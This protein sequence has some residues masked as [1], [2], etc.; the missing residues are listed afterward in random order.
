MTNY[1]LP[2][3]TDLT[4]LHFAILSRSYGQVQKRLEHYSRQIDSHYRLLTPLECALG[5][6]EGLRLLASAGYH[7]AEAVRLAIFR[8]DVDSIQHILSAESILFE[9]RP[10]KSV[11][12][13]RRWDEWTPRNVMEAVLCS[14]CRPCQRLISPW[15]PCGTQIC[16]L[17]TH[18][19]LKTETRTRLR[20]RNLLVDAIKNRRASLAELARKVFPLQKLQEL[21]INLEGP[22]DS[23]ALKAYQA[24]QD[25]G[26]YV[27]PA[28]Y[29][30]DRTLLFSFNPACK[31]G[32]FHLMISL[33]ENGLCDPTC[34]YEDSTPLTRI[35]QAPATGGL[36]EEAIRLLFDL[37][38][39][40]TFPASS[41]M[42]NFLFYLAYVY[43][44]P[45]RYQ[46]NH[47]RF[48]SFRRLGL[49]SASDS[50]MSVDATAPAARCTS[51]SIISMVARQCN[52]TQR[53]SC[54]CW[55]SSG[56]CLPLHKFQSQI[57]L[58]DSNAPPPYAPTIVFS[59][60]KTWYE[61]SEAL[62]AWIQDCH[63]DYNQTRQYLRDACRLE[64]F[65]R[66]GM[67]HTCCQFTFVYHNRT[68]NT[69]GLPV[70]MSQKDRNTRQELQEED[71]ELSDQLEIIMTAYDQAW[72]LYTG[73]SK[74]FWEWWWAKLQVL[75]PEIPTS[76]RDR[77]EFG[78]SPLDAMYF[79]ASLGPHVARCCC[80]GLSIGKN[81][82][83]NTELCSDPEPSMDFIDEIDQFFAELFSETFF[84]GDKA[85]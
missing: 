17:W 30:G 33:L 40:A 44:T 73:T 1:S 45:G 23:D 82:S 63:L 43:E 19:A 56:G 48:R 13:F 41:M 3:A 21:G 10:I 84:S 71:R 22:F 51:S 85:G 57:T 53:D 77:K 69:D 64:V 9:L 14:H 38:A 27:P 55:C 54:D 46:R 52:P 59:V 12:F 66:L 36:K 79:K 72:E 5:W 28:L 81:E 65:T 24:L 80:C 39:D 62:W 15:D 58:L 49:G 26:I 18:E 42:P 47:S 16:C 25:S 31:L 37:G 78:P 60:T 75:L 4:P 83:Q 35:F 29:P 7:A 70:L 50:S 20:A 34:C 8:Q 6:P 2:A 11:R 67:A 74:A 76:E 61:I 68:I 32:G